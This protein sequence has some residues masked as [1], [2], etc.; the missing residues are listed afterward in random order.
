LD[1]ILTKH[2]PEQHIAA[3]PAQY[4][5][6]DTEQHDEIDLYELVVSIVKQWKLIL[7][8]SF[9]GTVIGLFYALSLSKQYENYTLLRAPLNSDLQILELNGYGVNLKSQFLGFH[10]NIKSPEVFKQYLTKLNLITQF[11]P[12]L[13][14]QK[15]IDLA[16]LGLSSNL[17]VNFV[18]NDNE[19]T[20]SDELLRIIQIKLQSSKEDVAIDVLNKYIPYVE[21]QV[22]NQ[23]QERGKYLISLRKQ[24][25]Q[26]E[27]NKLRDL[28]KQNR[29]NT[30]ADLKE[31]LSVAKVMK[32]KK[33]MYI[34][35]TDKSNANIIN[36]QT[37]LF[38]KYMLGSDY[39]NA[40]ISRLQ[41]RGNGI[42]ADDS[43]ISSL[44]A[45][46][47]ELSILNKK[48]FNFDGAKLYI[49]DKLAAK[50]DAPVKPN[51]RL[52]AIIGLLLS[53]FLALFVALI[54][55]TVQKRKLAE[56]QI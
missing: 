15:D 34:M 21:Q 31:T 53:G 6:T 41:S 19:K 14:L 38:Q 51:K 29:L 8:I 43:F 16:L 10:D 4:Y 52:I 12:E 2:Q 37:N 48:T 50:N 32:V 25:I 7:L 23:I 56:S 44:P 54:T 28:A 5:I 30:I 3:I 1:I 47:S 11:Y 22:F 45:L 27:I 18:N 26:E 42:T 40:E 55:S 35:Q 39:L 17:S 13:T 46:L 36:K 33:A 49:L 9:L 20:K 24:Q